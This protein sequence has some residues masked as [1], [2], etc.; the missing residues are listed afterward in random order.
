M[1][2]SCDA[3]LNALNG[4]GCAGLKPAMPLPLDNICLNDLRLHAQKAN[5]ISLKAARRN[6]FAV[7]LALQATS[8]GKRRKTR[9][10]F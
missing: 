9:I 6:F 5:A 1:G 7:F 2:V 3:A 10:L 4:Y 8:V